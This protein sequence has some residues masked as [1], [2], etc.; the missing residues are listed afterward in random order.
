MFRV[1]VKGD[2]RDYDTFRTVFDRGASERQSW[3]VVQSEVWRTVGTTSEL[4]VCHDFATLTDANDYLQRA[5][6]HNAIVEAGATHVPLMWVTEE[7]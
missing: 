1:F 6:L 4:T 2:V 3:G 7:V 5:R